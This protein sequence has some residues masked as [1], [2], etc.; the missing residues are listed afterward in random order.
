MTVAE[1]LSREADKICS[2]I[3]FSDLPW[4]DIQIMANRLREYCITESP[5]KV[6]LFDAVYM[7]RFERLREQWR[8]D[9][10]EWSVNYKFD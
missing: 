9:E 7:S 4:I 6:E 8:L 3:L 2:L 5:E 1:K 10:D